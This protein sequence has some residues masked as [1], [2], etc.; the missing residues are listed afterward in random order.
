MVII[1][2]LSYPPEQVKEVAKRFGALPPL[3]AYITMKGPYVSSE[4]GVGIK[5][6]SLYEYDQSKTKEAMQFVGGRVAKFFGVPGFTYSLH[7]WSEV[8]EALEMV[9]LG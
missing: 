1:S 6:T 4:V 5:T 2:F 7:Y 8:S 9:G 3:P